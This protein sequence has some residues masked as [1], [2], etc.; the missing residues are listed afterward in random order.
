MP[1]HVDLLLINSP[2]KDYGVSTRINDFTLP[3]LG[4]AYIAT[5]AERSG[6]SVDVLDAEARALSITQV[7]KIAND[8]NP[9]W[10]GLNLLSPTYKI[11]TAILQGLSPDIKI[12]LGGHHAQAMPGEVLQDEAIPRID[13]LVLGEAETRV[14]RLLEDTS[15]RKSLPH[16][17]W[18]EQDGTAKSGSG[19]DY[20]LVPDIN[21]LPFV[22]R[23]FLVQDPYVDAGIVESAMVASR[24]CPFKCSFC[25]AAASATGKIRMRSASNIIDEMRQLRDGL[26][27]RRVR[28]VDDLFLASQKIMRGI[29]DAFAEARTQLLW[30]ANGRANIIAN[31]PNSLIDGMRE[32]GAH[33]IALGIESGSDR[34]LRHIGKNITATRPKPP[35]SSFAAPAVDVKGFFILGM[36]T[37]T[38]DE[39]AQTEAFIK[40]LWKTTEAMPGAFRCSIFAYRPYPGT[41][42]WNRL[43]AAG[44]AQDKLLNYTQE[45]ESQAP[46]DR[47]EFSFSTGL[48][49][50]EVP[51][52]EIK[53]AVVRIMQTQNELRPR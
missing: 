11:S 8:L 27:V 13:A 19:D 10:V 28:F 48:Q 41:T 29:F 44:F 32:S 5:N 51:V 2:L 3:T 17:Y 4:L 12:M 43:R 31:A 30:D 34:L 46:A 35:C 50:G 25:G 1:S 33:E 38:R 24:G 40:R 53:Q 37:E 14:V 23:K 16:V 26:G 7:I 20:W 21:A 49:F 22:N 39:Q 42:D 45:S 15:A 6:F 47:D 9:K 18:R 36:P 52:P